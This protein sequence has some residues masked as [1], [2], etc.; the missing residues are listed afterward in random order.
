MM[1]VGQI[2]GYVTQL[3][4]D[5]GLMPF[6]QAGMLVTVVVG[7]FVAVRRLMQGS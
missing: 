2:I 6:I 7:T 3:T 1:S 4:T 5:W